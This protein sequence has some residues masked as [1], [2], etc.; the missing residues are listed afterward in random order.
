[1][2]GPRGGGL[3]LD[4]VGGGRVTE[5]LCQGDHQQGNES[6]KKGAQQLEEFVAEHRENLR[7]VY[8]PCMQ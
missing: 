4:G 7:H 8:L 6:T 2:F 3:C 5:G 1:M